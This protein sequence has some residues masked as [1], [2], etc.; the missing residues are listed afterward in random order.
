MLASRVGSSLLVKG[1]PCV[2]DGAADPTKLW[3][4]M[5]ATK[6]KAQARARRLE[7]E[8]QQVEHTRRQR[9]VLMLGGV[10]LGAAIVLAVAI[11]ISSGG[12]SNGRLTPGNG[13]ARITAQVRQLLAGIPQS[14]ATLGNPKAPVTMTYYSDLQCP[15]CAD[16]TLNG[17]FPELLSRDVRAG[18][19]QIVDASLETATRD[20]KTF[21]SQQVAALAAGNQNHFWDYLEG[22]YRQQGAEGTGYVTDAYLTGL[23]DQIPGLDI[24]RWRNARSD[25]AL[26]NRVQSE[27]QAAVAAGVQGTP[28]LIFRGPR[29][30]A[31]SPESVPSYQQLEQVIKSVA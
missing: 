4:T 16:F 15:V 14:G 3:P 17:G 10:V 26:I 2:H 22:F 1:T 29:G 23:A 20:P 25:S 19:V 7:R 27:Q 6:Q 11:A 24:S 28:T 21:Q 12:G 13:G 30:Q 31:Q 9:R 18:Q 8:K 5:S